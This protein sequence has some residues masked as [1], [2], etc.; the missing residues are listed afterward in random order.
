MALTFRETKFADAWLM[1]SEPF[2]DHRGSFARTFC[3]AEL[4]A[5][6]L[7]TRFVQHSLSHSHAR[8]TVRGLHFQTPPHAET[9]IV[10][11]LAGEI[12]DVIVDLRPGSPTFKHWQAFTLSRTNRRQLYV[13][14]GFAHGFQALCDDVDVHYLIS[15]PY[16][17]AA[18]SGV[19][20]DDPAFGIAWPV[21]VTAISDK[22]RTW[23]D[24]T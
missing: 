5:R 15:T 19:R 4:G 2:F 3:E 17:P 9:K 12:F 6:G 1:E 14:K 24:F 8:G 11:C 7:E 16:A 21:P 20:Y 22:D 18:A 23:P 13:P 10:R